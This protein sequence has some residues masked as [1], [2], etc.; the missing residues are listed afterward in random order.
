MANFCILQFYFNT[1]I[2]MWDPTKNVNKNYNIVLW[3][4]FYLQ[5]KSVFKLM[6]DYL[7]QNM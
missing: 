2:V 3:V 6:M 1:N 7:I 4:A 5:F